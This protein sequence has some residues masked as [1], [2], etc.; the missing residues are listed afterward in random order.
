MGGAEAVVFVMKPKGNMAQCCPVI[1][2]TS[3][4]SRCCTKELGVGDLEGLGQVWGVVFKLM[5][6][7]RGIAT[8]TPC[9]V[10]LPRERE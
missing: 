9:S 2:E 4:P 7:I 6:H 8:K 5:G 10:M 1:A 3:E